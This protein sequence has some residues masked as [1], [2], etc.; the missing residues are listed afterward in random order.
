MDQGGN[1]PEGSMSY[2]FCNTTLF[3]GSRAAQASGA[4]R[5]SAFLTKRRPGVQWCTLS[6]LQPP[7]PR[8]KQFLCLS[9]PSSWDYRCLSLSPANVSVFLVETGFHCVGQAGLQLLTSSDL[10]ASASQSARTTGMSH[11]GVLLLLPRLEYNG[12]ISAHC[13]LCL[14][15]SIETGFL[16][17]GQARLELPASGNQP[18][19]AS[20]SVGITG[21]SHHARLAFVLVRAYRHTKAKIEK[22]TDRE[23]EGLTTAQI[24][25]QCHDHGSLQPQPPEIKRFPHLSLPSSWG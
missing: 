6:S 18:A 10:P 8:F 11:N 25:V 2:R 16:H 1:H 24:G 22:E 3:Q 7:S 15:G 21:M 13:N 9:P 4:Q 5:V 14:P 20:Q 12:V 23:K 19:S 17:V